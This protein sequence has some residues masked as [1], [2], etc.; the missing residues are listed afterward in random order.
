MTATALDLSA[1]NATDLNASKPKDTPEQIL[2]AARQFEALLISQLL[3]GAQEEGSDGWGNE[4]SPE[5]A[6]IGSIG[7]EQFAM[8][9]SQGGGLGLANAITA[10]ICSGSGAI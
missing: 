6:M 1:R 8:A 4:D 9:L 7:Q 5:T 10:K 3:K 2:K